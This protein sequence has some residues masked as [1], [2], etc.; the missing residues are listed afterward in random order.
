LIYFSI[1][2]VASYFDFTKFFRG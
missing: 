1:I 2:F